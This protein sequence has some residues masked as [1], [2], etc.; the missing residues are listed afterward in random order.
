MCSRSDPVLFGLQ[1]LRQ[2]DVPYP[3]FG[4]EVAIRFASTSNPASG[5]TPGGLR[6]YL[7]DP[8]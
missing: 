3:N 8:R 1:A 4:C 5:F 2:N 7:D 6:T